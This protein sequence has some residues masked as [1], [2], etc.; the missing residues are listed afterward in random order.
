MRTNETRTNN[1]RN[2]D[3]LHLARTVKDTIVAMVSFV[4][5]KVVVVG[6]PLVRCCAFFR[7]V[8]FTSPLFGFYREGESEVMGSLKIERTSHDARRN[9]QGL[10][11][12]R[13]TISRRFRQESQPACNPHKG[14]LWRP[15]GVA[16]IALKTDP[17]HFER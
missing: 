2:L 13:V 11:R 10:C 3:P 15:R 7:P 8:Q 17:T 16:S 5:V 4:L 9:C 6:S 12:L 14:D 1:S